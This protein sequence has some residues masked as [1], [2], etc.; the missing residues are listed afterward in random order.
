[1]VVLG[2]A[3]LV[4]HDKRFIQWKPTVLFGLFAVALLVSAVIGRRPL[5]QRMFTSLM[6]E[7]IA[8]SARGWQGLNLL[9]AVWFALVAAV[10]LY[11]AQSYSEQVWVY[12]HTYGVSAASLLFM[13]PQVFWLASRTSAPADGQKDGST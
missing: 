4:L 2:T 5:I 8:L 1:V 6:P 7:G 13:L 10:N 11:I 12:F 3:T 9:W